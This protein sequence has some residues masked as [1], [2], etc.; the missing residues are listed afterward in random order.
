MK[1]KARR[2]ATY[3]EVEN[4]KEAYLEN[5]LYLFGK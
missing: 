3:K 5:N 4:M 2:A 1:S